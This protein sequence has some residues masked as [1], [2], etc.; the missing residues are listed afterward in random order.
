MDEILEVRILKI[1]DIY[2]ISGHPASCLFT[3]CGAE[4]LFVAVCRCGRVEIR[5]CAREDHI[6]YISELVR[7]SHR[8][9]C[10]TIQ[11]VA[12]PHRSYPTE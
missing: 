9:K 8:T 7:V 4:A 5:T 12:R 2:D 11:G 1:P 10:L 3:E 6:E